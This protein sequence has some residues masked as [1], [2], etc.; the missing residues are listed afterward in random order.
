MLRQSINQ[1]PRCFP[2]WRDMSCFPS[3]KKSLWSWSIGVLWVIPSIS[4]LLSHGANYK[5][6]LDVDLGWCGVPNALGQPDNRIQL[7]SIRIGQWQMKSYT[8]IP[9]TV[10]Q[11]YPILSIQLAKEISPSRD[12]AA[13]AP[14]AVEQMLVLNKSNVRWWGW[15]TTE[16]LDNWQWSIQKPTLISICRDSFKESE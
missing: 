2:N 13:A 12:P 15:G 16:I 11:R 7:R 1:L 14:T 4:I 10:L 9:I 6:L 5:P 8:Q 3:A